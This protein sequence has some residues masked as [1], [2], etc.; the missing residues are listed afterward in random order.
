MLF[1]VENYWFEIRQIGKNHVGVS[2]FIDDPRT[3]LS[4]L[5]RLSDPSRFV[6]LRTWIT[7]RF[8]PFIVTRDCS[9][10]PPPK[11]FHEEAILAEG[12]IQTMDGIRFEVVKVGFRGMTAITEDEVMQLIRENPPSDL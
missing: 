5:T 10:P 9:V 12:T 11:N 3:A 1:N 4:P 6:P 8:I 2:A 7:E